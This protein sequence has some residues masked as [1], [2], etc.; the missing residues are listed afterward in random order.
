MTNYKPFLKAFR[1]HSL[2]IVKASVLFL[3]RLLIVALTLDILKVNSGFGVIAVVLACGAVF[4]ILGLSNKTRQSVKPDVSPALPD[5]PP[6]AP[7]EPVDPQKPLSQEEIDFYTLPDD[8]DP[9]A[10]YA[11]L[12]AQVDLPDLS[13]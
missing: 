10:C 8:E 6:I 4:G 2:Y 5:V 1:T 13:K 9:P 3:V 12:Y 11:G 7:A